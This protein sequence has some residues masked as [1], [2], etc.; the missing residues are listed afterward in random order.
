MAH[1]TTLAPYASWINT[2]GSSQPRFKPLFASKSFAEP[3]NSATIGRYDSVTTSMPSYDYVNQGTGSVNRPP[4]VTNPRSGEMTHCI[5]YVPNSTGTGA[6]NELGD[7]SA[8]ST[9]LPTTFLSGSAADDFFNATGDNTSRYK[10]SP[11]VIEIGVLGRHHHST[12]VLRAMYWESGQYS[13][14][15]MGNTGNSSDENQHGGEFIDGTNCI[16]A[17]DGGYTYGSD[18][19]RGEIYYVS[20]NADNLYYGQTVWRSSFRVHS[21]PN[22][23]LTPGYPYVGQGV[24]LSADANPTPLGATRII[25]ESGDDK[26]DRNLSNTYPGTNFNSPVGM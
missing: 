17:L 24:P 11:F 14:P 3:K 19:I 8:D 16:A 26:F 22:T 15:T 5:W 7:L 13:F 1:T 6:W 12:N 20:P 23:T 4:I 18:K 10:I 2:S 21:R 9:S 25:F